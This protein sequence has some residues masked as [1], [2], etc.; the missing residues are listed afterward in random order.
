MGGA[1]VN[2]LELYEKKIVQDEEF[3]AQVQTHSYETKNWGFTRHWHEHVELHY[4]LKGMGRYYVEQQ[5]YEARPGT[6]II[7]N[8]N[9][10]HW[11][12]CETVPFLDHTLIF[13]MDAFSKEM[14][15][16][17]LVFANAIHDDSKI[18]A[19][20]EQIWDELRLA[21]PGGKAACKAILIQM[22]VYLRRNYV[23]QT[24]TKEESYRKK[25]DQERLSKVISYIE[26][27]YT[28]PIN[29][30][31]LA[32]LLFISKGRFEHMFREVLGVSPLRYINELRLKK[33]LSLIRGS[34]SPIA[35]IASA[36]GF[37]DYNH[38]GRLFRKY[39]GCSPKQMQKTIK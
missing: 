37:T 27:H 3:P 35:D 32:D 22:L 29:N 9:E 5:E 8:S 18:R 2:I 14:D 26:R 1:S 16:E 31:E 15:E 34:D 36:V 33:T 11:G 19:Y 21:Q 17:N 10:L 38:F 28:E 20:M 25:R 30:Q 24:L 4:V 12:G 39:Y 23:M 6:L 7:A 13:R